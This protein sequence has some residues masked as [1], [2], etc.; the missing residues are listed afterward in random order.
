MNHKFIKFSVVTSL[1]ISSLLGISLKGNTQ[2]RLSFICSAG[3]QNN[4]VYPTTYALNSLQKE[5][6]TALIYWKFP[7]FANSNFTP[8]ERCKM[9]SRRFQEAY[10]NESL[11]FITNSKVND[12]PVICTSKISGGN[13]VTVLLT[14]RK[15]DDPIQVLTH[16]KNRLRGRGGDIIRHSP[17]SDN[18][19]IYYEIDID[20]LVNILD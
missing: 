13:C 4:K 7:W 20:K 15:S 1:L 16:L 17:R 9:V 10:D 18:I 14:L 19:S 3:K 11:R 6:R 5:E 8:Q 12:Q 2:E